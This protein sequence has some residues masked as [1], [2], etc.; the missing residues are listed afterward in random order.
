MHIEVLAFDIFRGKGFCKFN[1]LKYFTYYSE[2]QHK[3]VNYAIH[4]AYEDNFK[5]L[6]LSEGNGNILMTYN[7]QSK[8]YNFL[9][10]FFCIPVDIYSSQKTILTHC[11]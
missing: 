4:Q 1:Y 7:N 8:I 11:G 9:N 3:Y 2:Q 5:L 6:I 10:D